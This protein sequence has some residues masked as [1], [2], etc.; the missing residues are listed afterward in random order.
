MGDIQ[1][2]PDAQPQPSEKQPLQFRVGSVPGKVLIQYSDV[3]AYVELFP[4]VAEEFAK[5][6][7]HHAKK[8]RRH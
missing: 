2:Q 4:H 6:L 7:K 3:V 5:V 1:S 8:A